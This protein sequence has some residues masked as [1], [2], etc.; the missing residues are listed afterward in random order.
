M[1]SWC[2]FW[3]LFFFL[4]WI[5]L[6]WNMPFIIGLQKPSPWNYLLCQVFIVMHQ[7]LTSNKRKILTTYQ[8]CMYQVLDHEI[9]T[10]FSKWYQYLGIYNGH[11]CRSWLFLDIL[12]FGSLEIQNKL[13]NN[14]FSFQKA[15][16]ESVFTDSVFFKHLS[17]FC[18]IILSVVMNFDILNV[19]FS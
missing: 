19:Y 12:F 4:N 15:A 13:N 14:H 9:S 10:I 18:S 16:E 6:K 3:S 17:K 5:L 11:E 7:M 8:I 2:I 1:V